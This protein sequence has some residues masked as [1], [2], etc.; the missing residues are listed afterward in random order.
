VEKV[1][2]VDAPFA[3]YA[4]A[5]ALRRQSYADQAVGIG[6]EGHHR[7]GRPSPSRDFLTGA[8]DDDRRVRRLDPRGRGIHVDGGEEIQAGGVD[9]AAGG[10]DIAAGGVDIAA[11]GVDIAAGG[12]DIAA[13][14]R[15][16]RLH[17]DPAGAPAGGGRS[18]PGARRHARPD[19]SRIEPLETPER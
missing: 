1:A 19:R 16:R 2:I 6:A 18:A 10:V 7:Y 12:V 8:C 4:A 17:R 13:G 3:G 9:I 15:T 11:G 5:R 14:E